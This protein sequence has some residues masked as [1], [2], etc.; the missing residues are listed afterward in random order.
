MSFSFQSI[1][2]VIIGIAAV[3]YLYMR[4]RPK[5]TSSE[6]G[7]GSDCGCEKPTHLASGGV[8]KTSVK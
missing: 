2:V 1:A 8:K 3:Y 7:C 6:L 4:F 5:P